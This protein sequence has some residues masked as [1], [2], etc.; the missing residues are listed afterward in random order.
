MIQRTYGHQR[1]R[2]G[3]IAKIGRFQMQASGHCFQFVAPTRSPAMA[4]LIQHVLPPPNDL[5]DFHY[6]QNMMYLQLLHAVCHR[7]LSFTPPCPFV[8]HTINIPDLFEIVSVQLGHTAN[9]CVPRLCARS[10]L[11]RRCKLPG[12]FQCI[13]WSTHA[14]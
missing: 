4:M 3:A 13:E 2:Y 9:T 5:D 6:T 7:Q 14:H 1:E 11:D 10:L 8:C 12:T